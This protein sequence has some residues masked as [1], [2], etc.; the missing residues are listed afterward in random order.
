MSLVDTVS[1]AVDNPSL[2]IDL[3]ET[4]IKGLKWHSLWYNSYA[5]YDRTSIRVQI[6][7]SWPNTF[8]PFVSFVSFSL[9][10]PYDGLAMTASSQR[11]IASRRNSEEDN[12]D[13]RSVSIIG[14]SCSS[15]S[16][17]AS[18]RAEEKHETKQRKKMAGSMDLL[19][20][21]FFPSF[22]VLVTVVLIA[23]LVYIYD[24][25]DGQDAETYRIAGMRVP[26]ILALI[27]SLAVMFIAGGVGL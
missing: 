19:Q 6:C 2:R 16:S 8:L 14:G 15:S 10:C 17:T 26:T 12:E 20:V 13:R 27:M 25:A 24:Q 1:D 5:A 11:S 3:W 4:R 22:N 9:C 21:T 18:S 23:V 7:S